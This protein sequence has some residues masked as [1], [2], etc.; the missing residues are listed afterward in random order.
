MVISG[1]SLISIMSYFVSE[2]V[3]EEFPR[4]SFDPKPHP[5]DFEFKED[6]VGFRN[7]IKQRIDRMPI[8]SASPFPIQSF[9]FNPNQR[10][11]IKIHPSGRFRFQDM[12]IVDQADRIGDIASIRRG[13]EPLGNKPPWPVTSFS[14]PE[15]T[16]STIKEWKA[17]PMHSTGRDQVYAGAT[18]ARNVPEAVSSFADNTYESSFPD[19]KNESYVEPVTTSESQYMPVESDDRFATSSPSPGWA[20]SSRGSYLDSLSSSTMLKAHSSN[21]DCRSFVNFRC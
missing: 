18:N 12:Y 2:L 1:L 10:T 15:S 7:K 20:P 17:T 4:L 5:D 9:N 11:K 14:F 3:Q 19:N 6:V 16:K 13:R 21:N 8:S